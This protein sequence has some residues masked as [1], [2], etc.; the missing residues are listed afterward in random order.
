MS[1]SLTIASSL[2]RRLF[3]TKQRL[4]GPQAEPDAR[5]LLQ[6]ARSLGC[7]QLDPISVVARSHQLVLF[8]RVGVYDLAHLDQLLWQERSLFEYWGHC[9]SI[10]LTEDYPIHNVRMRAYPWGDTAWSIRTRQWLKDN[11]KLKRYVLARLRQ[12][13]PTLARDLEEDGIDP[14]AWVSGGWTSGRN[15]SSML[16][17][18]WLSG[19][20]MV[21]GRQGIQKAWD[22]AERCLPEWTPRERLTEHEMT[23]RAAE[24]SLR[25]LGVGTAR[26]INYHFIRGRYRDLPKVLNELEAEGKI[27]RLEIITPEA[28]R[29]GVGDWN[30]V[31]YIHTDDEPLLEE[32]RHMDYGLRTTLLSP[33]DNLI[34][35]RARTEQMFNFDFRIEIYTPPAK[36]KYGYY[37]LPILHGDQLIGRVD[38]EMDRANGQLR[39]NAVFAEPDAPRNAGPAVARAIADLATFLGAREIR[40]NPQRVPSFWKR[41]LKS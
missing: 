18:L 23:R 1:S 24:K 20:I 22:L 41:A 34:C 27:R 19:Q 17:Y 31:W 36:R 28:K 32:L 8:S 10:V 35:D 30:G 14:K 15:I 16:D 39:V 40:Y 37:V 38:P 3:I 25:A 13:G 33:F 12:H 9:A 29:S 26:H 11:P 2:A 4:T 6:V 21:A 5:G 7:L